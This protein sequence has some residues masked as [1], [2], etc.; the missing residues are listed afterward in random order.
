[1][2]RNL[3]TL[4]LIVKNESKYLAKCVSS[5][6]DIV[7]KTVIIDTGSKDDTPAI[8]R[9]LADEFHS[10]PFENDFSKARNFAL[11]FVKTPWVLY[12]DAD[13]S[14]ETLD[15][16]NLLQCV[17]EAPDSV[18]GYQLTR[19]NFFGT[20]GWY[21]SKNLKVFRNSPQIFYEGSVSESATKSI[22]RNG[23]QIVDA[24]VLLNHYGHCRS[25]QDRDA[26]AHYYL[27][28]M[29]GEIEKK[30]PNSR[31]M[32]YIGMILRTLGRFE[33][34]LE[35]ASKGLSLS[36]DSAHSHYCKAQ[37]LRSMNRIEEA[38]IHYQKASELSPNDPTFWNMVGLMHMT[39]GR[40]DEAEECFQKTYALN[41]ILIH[42]YV[43]LGLLHQAK[44]NDEKALECFEWVAG[45]NRGFLHEDFASRMECDP[46]REF[47]YETIFK[48]CGLGYHLAYAREKLKRKEEVYF[49][50]YA[51]SR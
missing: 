13:E 1:M 39:L 12:L 29:Q 50:G 16:E 8:A 45:R 28:L 14:F 38:L 2:N 18:W 41:P 17:S 43:N 36:P 19:Y 31:L 40:Y 9:S 32:G 27:K 25:V 24:P 21:T 10:I 51:L 35:T 26:K 46:Y 11:Q 7:S 48:Y 42:A 23:G 6:A 30:G 49:H 5:A 20:G 44:G 37:V 4:C 47:Y 15:A 34:G 3:M 33:E 22:Q